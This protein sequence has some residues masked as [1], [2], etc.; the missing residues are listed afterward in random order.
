MQTS[1]EPFEKYTP[2]GADFPY[3]K[4]TD[5]NLEGFN[6]TIGEQMMKDAAHYGIESMEQTLEENFPHFAMRATAVAVDT[7]SRRKKLNVPVGFSQDLT[8]K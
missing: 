3:M 1:F 5:K 6:Y 8:N 4:G 7:G 2:T